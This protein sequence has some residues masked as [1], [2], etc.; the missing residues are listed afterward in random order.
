MKKKAKAVNPTI[1]ETLPN[2]ITLVVRE[3]H[4]MPTISAAAYFPGGK[5]IETIEKNGVAPLSQRLIVRGTEN[6]PANQLFEELE[7]YGIKLIPFYGKDTSGLR[8]KTLSRHFDHAMDLF[9]QV[10][11]TPTFPENEFEKEKTNLLEEIHKEKDHLLPYCVEKCENLVFEGHPYALYMNGEKESVESLT[12][13]DIV[14][15]YQRVYCPDRMTIA[16]VGDIKADYALEKMIEHFSNFNRCSEIPDPGDV[17]E[18]IKNVR[19]GFESTQKQQVAICLG[20]Q[21]PSIL[22]EDFYTFSV[23]NQVLSGMGARLFIELRDKMGLGYTVNSKYN[24]YTSGGIFRAYILT[25]YK[26]KEKARLALLE[27]V[28]RL[29]TRLVSYDE[30]VRAKR[31][32]LGLFEIGLQKNISIASKLAY[33]EMAGVGYKFLDEYA[34]KI[35]LITRQ[36]VKRAAEKYLRPQ[37]Y[38]IALLTPASFPKTLR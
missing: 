37:S 11:Q 25:S 26:H 21:A 30:L 10:L 31:Y 7:N 32:H 14:N 20:F 28:D 17:T 13:D 35:K 9:S 15:Y 16:L 34:G 19:E 1:K 38:A 29:R 4:S 12:R 18:P 8:M 2:G 6:F 23:L 36:K 24:P 5:R 27:E 33:Y 3:N 22:S